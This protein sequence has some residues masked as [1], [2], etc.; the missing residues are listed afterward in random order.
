M[1]TS[2][3]L[4]R[5]STTHHPGTAVRDSV[6]ATGI[7]SL[8]WSDS[9]CHAQTAH[10]LRTPLAALR[11]HLEEALRYPAEVD[12]HTA[13]A[14]ALTAADRLETVITGLLQLTDAASREAQVDGGVVG[15]AAVAA[16]DAGARQQG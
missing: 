16:A 10:E 1:T 2:H 4:T 8:P 14:E 11:L 13:L 6:A 12:W 9:A 7:V 3:L 15:G 5:C